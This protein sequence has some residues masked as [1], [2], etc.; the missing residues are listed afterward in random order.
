MNSDKYDASAH[1]AYLTQ[2]ERAWNGFL[3]GRLT[4]EEVCAA[5]DAID[6]SFGLEVAA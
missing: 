2:I 3:L 6:R 4:A 5:L 1:A